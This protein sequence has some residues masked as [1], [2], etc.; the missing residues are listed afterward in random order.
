MT[1]PPSGMASRAFTT[2]LT[3]AN[4]NSEMSIESGH[5]AGGTAICRSI[6]PRAELA[7]ISSNAA[8]VCAG[9]TVRG[10]S[11][12]RRENISNCR[13]SVSPRAAAD[14]MASSARTFFGSDNRRS[15]VCAWPVT[16]IS[17]L[18]KSCATPPVSWPSASIFCA[19]A[20]C[21]CA[22][23]SVSWASRRSV[24]SRVILAKPIR[25][26]FAL[27]MASIRTLAEKRLAALAHAPGLGFKLAGRGRDRER[28]VRQAA[29]AVGFGVELREMPADDFPLGIAFDA[30]GAGVPAR[31]VAVRIEHDEGVVDRRPPSAGAIAARWRADVRRLLFPW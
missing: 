11:D 12:W 20:S 15:N 25:S 6:L 18:L 29:G 30:F 24:M 19:C 31:H 27:R 23:S 8:M 21:A 26:P 14:W 17:R 16:I 4:S 9:E 28:A 10:L 5:V 1:W 2:R 13:V 3:S 7:S 22:S